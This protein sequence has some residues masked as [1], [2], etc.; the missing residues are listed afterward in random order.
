MTRSVGVLILASAVG[1]YL[2]DE[3]GK[4]SG[5]LAKFVIDVQAPARVLYFSLSLMFLFTCA[6]F[7]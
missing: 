5:S 3:I 6:C 2:G 4:S 1:E 7:L